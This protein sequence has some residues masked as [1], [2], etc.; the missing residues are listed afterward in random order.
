MRAYI[1]LGSNLGDRPALLRAAVEALQL[2]GIRVMKR[3]PVYETD[4]V[5]GPPQSPYYN[6]V[7]EIETDRSPRDLLALC[8][9]VEAALGRVRAN[10]ERFGPRPIDLD[11]LLVEG[12]RVDEEDLVIPHPRLHERAFALVPLA[13]IAP[14]AEV[15][16]RGTVGEL[17]AALSDRRGVRRTA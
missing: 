11:I 6:Q 13:D 8:H 5:G 1:C 17:L 3:S 15:G 4:P 10:E 12:Q 9:Q 16:D 2:R 14:G 7:I